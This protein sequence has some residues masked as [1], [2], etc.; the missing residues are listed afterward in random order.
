MAGGVKG[1]TYLSVSDSGTK[2]QAMV[3]AQNGLGPIKAYSRQPSNP[4]TQGKIAIGLQDK[5]FHCRLCNISVNSEVKLKQVC[6]IMFLDVQQS[7]DPE[8]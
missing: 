3:D 8:I 7:S 4:H 1:H 2:H 5:M 6:M